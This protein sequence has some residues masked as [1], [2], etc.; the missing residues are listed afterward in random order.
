[1]IKPSNNCTCKSRVNPSFIDS[2]SVICSLCNLFKLFALNENYCNILSLKFVAYRCFL[3]LYFRHGFQGM[4]YVFCFIAYFFK[5]CLLKT[6]LYP[7]INQLISQNS[8]FILVSFR[9]PLN[10]WIFCLHL[11]SANYCHTS[12]ANPTGLMLLCEVALGNM[13]ELEH[14]KAI[15]KL[16]KGKHSC[17]GQECFHSASFLLSFYIDN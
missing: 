1:M 6:F 16:P 5:L 15:D 14:A 7:F 4:F 11:Q 12:S 3:H 9:Y 17:K 13:Y 2:C 10:H 8:S